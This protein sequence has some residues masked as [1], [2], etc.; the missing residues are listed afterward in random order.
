MPVTFPKTSNFSGPLYVAGLLFGVEVT[1]LT[2]FLHRF[3]HQYC[4]AL[5]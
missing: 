4:K 5:V 1:L 3:S 2:L